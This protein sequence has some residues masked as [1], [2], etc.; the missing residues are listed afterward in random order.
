MGCPRGLLEVLVRNRAKWEEPRR[1]CL[2]KDGKFALLPT[3]LVYVCFRWH[4]QE[5]RWGLQTE[6][7][8]TKQA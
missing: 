7:D 8:G 4:S 6:E 1:T 3:G 5:G 2:A